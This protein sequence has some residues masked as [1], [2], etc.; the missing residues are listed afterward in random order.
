MTQSKQTRVEQLEKQLAKLQRKLDRQTNRAAWY[1]SKLLKF[2]NAKAV[3]E[4]L[5]KDG[6]R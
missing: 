1:R 3:N 2:M 6:M 5:K 4:E